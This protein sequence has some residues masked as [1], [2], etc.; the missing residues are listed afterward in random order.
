MEKMDSTE[1]IDAFRAAAVSVTSLF[2]AS[3]AAQNKAHAEGYQECLR[4]L[5]GFLDAENLGLGDGEGWKVRSWATEKMNGNPDA[6]VQDRESEDEIEKAETSSSPELARTTS[7]TALSSIR[8]DQTPREGMASRGERTDSAPPSLSNKDE[9]SQASAPVL[10]SPS[11]VV[12]T[13]NPHTSTMVHAT[14]PPQA[15]VTVPTQDHF[16][17]QSTIQYPEPNLASLQISESPSSQH[18]MHG[19][20]SHLTRTS[21][22]KHANRSNSRSIGKAVTGQKR[23]LNL[24]ELFNLESLG[25]GKD[26]FGSGR[27]KRRHIG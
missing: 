14:L 10:P 27:E 25:A 21:R 20:G 1:L 22:G 6:M 23:K 13:S 5:I 15:I 16:T 11:T 4:D 2:K 9:V 3:T 19:I 12:H 18:A 8:G 7:A 17:F 26:I 24:T